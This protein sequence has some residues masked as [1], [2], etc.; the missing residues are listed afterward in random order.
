M[1]SPTC[2]RA[3]PRVRT[4]TAR[5]STSRS[6]AK[7]SFA[8]RAIHGERRADPIVGMGLLLDADCV[9]LGMRIHPGNESE[10]PVLKR[11]IDEM[12]RRAGVTGKVVRVADKG[13]NCADNVADAVLSGRRLHLLQVRQAIAKSGGSHGSSP[14]RAGSMS[15]GST[16]K[17]A[18]ATR[19]SS[20]TS[21]TRST[22][23]TA[24]K[25]AVALPEKRV[26]TYSPKSS[27][28]SSSPR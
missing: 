2:G 28:K 13:L 16:A 27:L 12:R 19:K 6:T 25:R 4:S 9:P 1:P 24:R 15:Q 26:A 18:T 8:A 10:K 17:R 11:A 21:S 5:T 23:R 20:A 14:T 3:K 7:T 22:A